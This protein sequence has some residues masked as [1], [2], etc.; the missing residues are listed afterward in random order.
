MRP[1]NNKCC[2]ALRRH[3]R[4]RSTCAAACTVP[5]EKCPE[6]LPAQSLLYRQRMSPLALLVI[7][8]QT[9]SISAAPLVAAHAGSFSPA[10]LVTANADD[11]FSDAPLVSAREPAPPAE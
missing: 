10:P 4:L 7:L 5:R 9:N 2:A 6:Q 1:L 8:T 3:A 11:T